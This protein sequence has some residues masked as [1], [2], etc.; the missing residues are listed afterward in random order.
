MEIRTLVLNAHFGHRCSQ[1]DWARA[2]QNYANGEDGL[3]RMEVMNLYW[4]TSFVNGDTEYY[5]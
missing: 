3:T 4:G 5:L 2:G 1:L